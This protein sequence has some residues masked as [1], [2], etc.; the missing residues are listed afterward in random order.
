M[1]AHVPS[2]SRAA[3]GTQ[4]ANRPSTASPRLQ[5]HANVAAR[6]GGGKAASM[7]RYLDAMEG[8]AAHQSLFPPTPEN[9]AKTLGIGAATQR[10]ASAVRASGT[11][12]ASGAAPVNGGSSPAAGPR[13]RPRSAAALRNTGSPRLQEGL[14]D[15]AQHQAS[16]RRRQY[17]RTSLYED[18]TAN[19]AP[20]NIIGEPAYRTGSCCR[21]C[22]LPPSHLHELIRAPA[23]GGCQAASVG[24]R[25]DRRGSHVGTT[26]TKGPSLFWAPFG[27]LTLLPCVLNQ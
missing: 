6:D 7:L 10:P 9:Q 5:G 14:L 15:A 8:A 3:A 2:G 23:Q 1:N 13:Q 26:Q 21:M 25:W 27:D 12:A 20:Y 16:V 4:T 19:E 22:T 18:G 24:Q 11:R 17:G